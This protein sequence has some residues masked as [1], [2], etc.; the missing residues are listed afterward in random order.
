MSLYSVS[1]VGNAW[2]LQSIVLPRVST[3]PFAKID[4]ASA[5]WPI[6]CCDSTGCAVAEWD[7]GGCS[8]LRRTANAGD[9]L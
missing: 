1:V 7:L 8:D 3:V 4:E 6:V 2:G 9:G 5:V